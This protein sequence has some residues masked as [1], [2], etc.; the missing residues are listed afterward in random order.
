MTKKQ[1]ISLTG[2]SGHL[3]TCLIT[4]LL[5]QQFT[6]KALYKNNLPKIK[7]PNLIWI[8]GDVKDKNC[9]EKLI[10]NTSVLVHSASII[11]IGEK[12]RDTVYHTNVIGTEIV[13][14]ACLNKNIQLIY[15]SSSNAVKETINDDVFDESRPYKTET[16]FLYGYTKALAEQNVLK[17]VT[18]K[19]LDALIIRPTSIIGPPDYIPSHFGQTILDMYHGNIPAL[20]TG[21]Y[22]LVDVRDV[23]QTIINSFIKGKTGAVY[24]VGGNYFS[25]KEISKM[26][27]SKRNPIIIPLDILIFLS[28]LFSVFNKLFK[29]RWPVTRESLV[30]L[31]KA[32]KNVD[33]SKAI[34]NLNHTIRPTKN[35]IENLISWFKTENKI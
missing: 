23:S 10:E 19:S 24:L 25:L 2:G 26:A 22:N 21:G 8:K 20:T 33:S 17:A 18:T 31:K 16:D 4:L 14:E 5:E 7:H 28:P 9:I 30:I 3:G 13:I 32:P 29:M 34:E 15:I 1:Q 11:S 27:N 12:K 6:V 35:S